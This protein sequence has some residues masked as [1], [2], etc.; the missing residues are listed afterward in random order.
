[1]TIQD[2]NIAIAEM[3]GFKTNTKKTHWKYPFDNNGYLS[4]AIS[5]IHG[6]W[7]TQMLK[8]DTD[9]N[10][11]SEAIEWIEKQGYPFEYCNNQ[12]RIYDKDLTGWQRKRLCPTVGKTP[13]EAIFEALYEF[14]QYLKTIND[15]NNRIRK[16]NL[17]TIREF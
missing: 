11:Q 16:R 6:G 13:K 8:F 12:A 3:L 10:W 7:L 14:S 9:A 4:T 2:K 15:N 5:G 17:D 1:M